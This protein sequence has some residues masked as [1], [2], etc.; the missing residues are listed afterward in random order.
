MPGT[1]A[2][3]LIF[4]GRQRSRADGGRSAAGRVRRMV[5]RTIYFAGMWLYNEE[6][7]GMVQRTGW[8][9]GAGRAIAEKWL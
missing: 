5:P 4:G 1:F 7:A 2:S 8:V 3:A 6:K 9:T